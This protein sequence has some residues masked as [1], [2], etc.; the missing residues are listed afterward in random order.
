[1]LSVGATESFTAEERARLAPYFTNVDAPVFALVNLPEVVKGALFARYSRSPK[2][3]RRLFLD[4]FAER[5]WRA[6]RPRGAS[7]RPGRSGSSSASSSST[8]TTRS[9]SWAASTS[10]ARASPTS[11][12]S[13]SSGAASWPTSSSR[14]AMCPTRT[15]PA[16]AGATTS[17]RKSAGRRSSASSRRR[18]I[19]VRDVRPVARADAG[20]LSPTPPASAVGCRGRLPEH[21]P[22]KGARHPPRAPSGRDAVERGTLRHG[23]GVRGP[24]APTPGSPLAEARACADL[25]LT[26]LR[27]VIPAFLRRVD[28]ADRGG[29]WSDYLAATG[30]AAASAAARALGPLAPEPRP[31]CPRGLRSRGRDEGRRRRALRRLGP[32]GRPAARARPADVRRGAGGG[33]AR[34]RGRARNRRH[35]P[36]RAF[37]R[38]SYRFDILTDYGA[39]RDLQ[40]HRLLT[41][42]WQ[43][44]GPRHGY[45]VPAAIE[46]AGAGATGDG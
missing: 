9:R 46:E 43:P 20:A 32:A 10:R 40:R 12:R 13:S 18:S 11:S 21:H 33:P 25:M 7:A 14:P 8:G 24:P 45:A 38:T 37:E 3:L 28:T 27:K 16:D 35:K 5:P 36:G 41:L 42:E 34:V 22:G 17:R 39:F 4:E 2:S 1:M 31:E 29:A 23:P 30:A 26:E 19:C 44:L 6:W 15:G